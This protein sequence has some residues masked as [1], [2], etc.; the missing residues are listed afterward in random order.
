MRLLAEDRLRMHV[1]FAYTG[2]LLRCTLQLL[3][4]DLPQPSETHRA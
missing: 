3:D 1:I 2:S 4:G